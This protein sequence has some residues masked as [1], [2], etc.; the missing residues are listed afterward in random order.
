MGMRLGWSAGRSWGRGGGGEPLPPS[1][2]SLVGGGGGSGEG[3]GPS[4]SPSH[5]LLFGG[6]QAAYSKSPPHSFSS[7][8]N[9]GSSPSGRAVRISTPFSVTTMVSSNCAEREP[10]CVTAVQLSGH[11]VSS[12]RP[13]L[14]MGSMVKTWPTCNTTRAH[15][16]ARA[17]TQAVHNYLEKHRH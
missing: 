12:Q 17:H 14:I 3:T 2:D 13:V 11:S 4:Q 6:A 9:W 15:S 8:M 1:S 16:H 10:S 5:P 7:L